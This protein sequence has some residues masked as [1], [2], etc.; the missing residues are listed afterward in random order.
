MSLLLFTWSQIRKA[1]ELA[2]LVIDLNYLSCVLISVLRSFFYFRLFNYLFPIFNYNLDSRFLSLCSLTYITLLV[3]RNAESVWEKQLRLWY[4]FL[5]KLQRA[6]FVQ[7]FQF[8]VFCRLFLFCS[9]LSP[10]ILRWS[11]KTALTIIDNFNNS[12]LLLR[13][14]R[15]CGYDSFL[16]IPRY[17][18]GFRSIH[19]LIIFL[20]IQ[21]ININMFPLFLIAQ[22][23][24]LVHFRIILDLKWLAILINKTFKLQSLTFMPIISIYLVSFFYF[25]VFDLWFFVILIFSTVVITPLLLPSCCPSSH[26]GLRIN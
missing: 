20:T 26:Y 23:L 7:I 8:L 25:L 5:L 4:S 18:L 3:L 16:F 24:I 15:Y 11:Y 17:N 13:L 14:L 6:L 10:L 2:L 1:W 9:S 12:H 21:I 19:P 22:R